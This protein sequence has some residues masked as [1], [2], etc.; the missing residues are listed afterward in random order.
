MCLHNTKS[1][2]TNFKTSL[3]SI[4]SAVTAM[5]G[6]KAGAYIGSN[7]LFDTATVNA[8]RAS[9]KGL[10]ATQ[11]EAAL[12]ASGLTAAQRQQILTS[13]ESTV[14]NAGQ[15][16]SFNVLTKAV[17]ANV[18]AMAKWLV[19]TPTGWITL[20]IGATAGL[21][22]AYNNVEKKQN[23]LIENARNLQEEY[24][25]FAKDTAGKITSLEGQAEEFN[26]LAK[27]VDKYGNNISLASDE[28]DRYKSIVAEI[29]GYS[30]ELIQG[31]DAEG[32]AIADKNGLLER[33]I[34][35]LKEEQRLKL[36]EMT[37]DE[38]TGEAYDAAE[39]GWQQVQGYE[40]ANTRNEIARW[41]DN[42]AL[43]GGVN[44]EVDIAKVLGIKDEWKEEGN[45]LQNAI[46]NNIDTVV[47]NIKDK[48]AEL[49]A[50]SD[51]DGNAIFSV[52]EIDNMIDLSN[53]WQYAYNQWQQDIEDAK[54]GMDDQ[55]DLY[56]QRAKSYSDLT[57][58][59]K[60]F[61]NEYIRATGDITDAE[62]HLLSED[63]I[64]EKAKGYE[65]F[66][67]EFAE[68]N[69]LGEGGSVDLT[70]RPEIDTEELNKK[71]WEAGE[72]FATVF[73]S[74]ISNTDFED[75][76]PTS[77]EDTV[78]I[79]FTPIIVDPNT[80]EFKGVLSEEELYAYAHDVLAGVRE[81]DL[82]LQIGAKFE[83]KNAIDE[84]VADG[85]RIHY[86]HEKLFI[87]NDTVDSWE[88]LRKV[89]VKTGD[90]AV[91]A[92]EKVNKMTVSIGELEAVSD[93]VKTLG[94]AFKELSDDGYITTKTLGEIQTATGLSGDEWE[95]YKTKLLNAKLGSSEFNQ[96][97]SEMT[98]KILD[99]T[100]AG[101]D[102]NNVSE[103]YVASV[104]KENGV[105]NASAVAHDYLKRKK[106]ELKATTLLSKINEDDF[107]DSIKNVATECGLT[108]SAIAGM[109]L[110]M[111]NL[112][113]TKLDLSQQIAEITKLR[114]AM[115]LS[116]EKLTSEE[117][118][119]MGVKWV[120]TPGGGGYSYNGKWYN[121]WDYNALYKDVWSDKTKSDFGNTTPPPIIPNYSGAGE[122]SG[123]DKNTPTYED[124]TEAVINRINLKA[125]ELKLDEE[126]IKNNIENA[127]IE[128]DYA[129]QLSLT[130]DLLDKRRDIITGLEKANS[131]LNNEA[132][133]LRNNN[134]FYNADGTESDEELWFD[135]QGNATEYYNSLI[136]KD[137]ITK[138]EQD[139]IKDLFEKL[140]KYKKA[141]IDNK[142][143]IDEINQEIFKGERETIPQLWEDIADDN[144][145]DIEH[146]IE[147]RNNLTSP[148]HKA[149]IADYEAIKEMAHT[150]A[151]AWRD[152]GFS[153]DSEEIQK[154]QKAWWD[155]ENGIWEESRKIFDKR[156]QLSEDYIQHS[157]DF[158]WENGD[159]E[160]DARKRVLDWIESDY[161]KSLIN[162]DEEYYKILE[163][164]RVKYN[165]ALKEE[166]SKAT[167]L[168]N[169]Y[170]DSQKTLLQSHF[171]VENSIAEARHEI[172]KELET[173]KTMYEYLDEE[174]RKLLFN[175]EDYNKLN[176]E[177]KRIENE[178]LR[179]QSEYDDKLRRSTLETVESITSE[180]QMQ[181]E[182]L[183]KSYEIAKADLEIA[184]KKQKLNNVLNERNV[185]MFING[186]WQWV[187]NTEDVANAK[188]ELA[189]AEYAK[190]VEES[191]LAQQNSIN[192]LTRQQDALG[193]VVKKFENGV[194]N[195][196]EAVYL[197]SQAI[198]DIPNA[199]ASMFSNIKNSSSSTSSKK[200]SSG[201]SDW[202]ATV[203]NA[204][205]YAAGIN[206]ALANGDIDGALTANKIRNEKI[207]YLGLDAEKWSDEDIKRRAKGH[208][209]G[210]RYTPGGL[211]LMG[212][213]GF[214]AY[215]TSNGQLI[216]INQP[217]IGNIPSGGVVFNADQMKNL[218][219]L[220][221]MSNLNLSVNK[222][223]L[224]KMQPHQVDQSQNNSITINGMVVDRG[225]SDGQALIN[226]LRRYVGNH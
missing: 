177:L 40:G 44:Y 169:T 172:N 186:S 118:Y 122:N 95:E 179:L 107:A 56:A 61:V 66:V 22:A 121:H 156:L 43:R 50:I 210:T 59:Q 102:L 32:N 46:I 87:N 142:K 190:R 222:G 171:D 200:N 185:R 71:G 191:G 123:S 93:K 146:R 143:E 193:V 81:D 108:T 83:G 154:W 130:N 153:E 92:G 119:K 173:S 194:I 6:I 133:W 97:M 74:A 45:N 52:D 24:R 209:T 15:A 215:V 126:Q 168:A 176:N 12:S 70:F 64:L 187:A 141:W 127:E 166:F 212:E 2:S 201:S 84:A 109:M 54:H 180:Y 131:D 163:E 192:E 89:L 124:P 117:I 17:W 158:G 116:T 114:W 3:Q 144:V 29:L 30:P 157:I 197:A 20:A 207:D 67:N 149:N 112:N 90:D 48:K 136:N 220:W 181:Y 204:N 5:Q 16:T 104:L 208:A 161:Y 140:S 34:E 147:M 162:N 60:V 13:K 195:L 35:L 91:Q 57:D 101:K 75:L 125:K 225:S 120:D 219:T 49:L 65:K 78:A 80:G 42:N 214:E 37:T 182:T 51:S 105:V 18:K 150:R 8:Y 39:A 4:T 129:K 36:K 62:G 47:K 137:G 73:S 79:N 85:E 224:N 28:Y 199:V 188:A 148:D 132:T 202:R 206:S 205:D 217:S 184:K 134:T 223:Y 21:I 41:F 152:A 174:T 98:Y 218:R 88:E 58:A 10:S 11:A 38:K 110:K 189:D 76:M 111:I 100:F 103:E 82:N 9:I 128:G 72:G 27:G 7:G 211:T 151:Q 96:V 135:S 86:L 106:A 221:D 139:R 165:D 53:D 167:D 25:S 183:M 14:A 159:S 115:G 68:L 178:S 55:F 155:A 145:S 203:Y 26:K 33:S 63:K 196:D 113:E 31:Y 77:T 164:N 213:D 138:E 19:T 99:S 1:N 198:G 160:I 226:A 94:T 216:P 69:K 170:K 23:E 175:Q